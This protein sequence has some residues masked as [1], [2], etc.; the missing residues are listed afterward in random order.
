[1]KKLIV[2]FL[3]IISIFAYNVN[4]KID[5]RTTPDDTLTSSFLKL[6]KVSNNQ[7]KFTFDKNVNLNQPVNLQFTNSKFIDI[8]DTLAKQNKLVYELQSEGLYMIYNE[9]DPNYNYSLK[10]YN[11]IIDVNGLKTQLKM[12]IPSLEIVE[13]VVKNSIY[14]KA[15]NNEFATIDNIIDNFNR[16][17]SNNSEYYVEKYFELDYQNVDDIL[18]LLQ[19][20]YTFTNSIIDKKNNGMLLRMLKEDEKSII[21]LLSK[22]DREKSTVLV[23]VQV[24][25][26]N[27]GNEN[28]LGF[29]WGEKNSVGVDLKNFDISSSLHYLLPT[30][31][32]FTDIMTNSKVLSK[33]SLLI[34]DNASASILVG[35]QIPIVTAVQRSENSEQLI[36]QVDYKNVGL[37][38]KLTPQIHNSNNKITID[39]DLSVDSLGDL[40]ATKYGD[41]YSINSKKVKTQLLLEDKQLIV[42]GGLISDEE[43]K[44]KV[45]VPILGRIPVLGRL[46]RY[47]ESKPSNTEIILSIKPIIISKSEFNKTTQLANPQAKELEKLENSQQEVVQIQKI[48]TVQEKNTTEGGINIEKAN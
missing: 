48:E 28:N 36:P 11:N 4:T 26:Y 10:L 33:P 21:D 18:P 20:Y 14:V 38:L 27:K 5:F 25:E 17:T 42:L 23:E 39:L 6:T 44:K 16:A 8:L 32:N 22:L 30:E 7:V 45:S 46:F 12:L 24:L 31:F 9:N 1:M 37:E 13:S 34:V 35:E 40:L 15:K 29:K 19:K 3:M 47:D 2:Y 43:R 41:Y